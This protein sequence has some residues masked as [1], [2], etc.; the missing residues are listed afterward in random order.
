MRKIRMGGLELRL[1]GGTDGDGGGPGALVVLFHGYGAPG[2]DL[3]ALG[4]ALD[5]PP[6]TRFAFPEA[7]RTR[8]RADGR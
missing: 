4:G 8:T 5:A 2:D 7:W 1:T 3:V 6:G